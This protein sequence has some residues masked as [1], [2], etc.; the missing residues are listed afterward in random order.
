MATPTAHASKHAK[1]GSDPI[2]PESIGAMSDYKEDIPANSNMNNYTSTGLYLVTTANNKT[3]ANAAFEG[4][5]GTFY[6]VTATNN[7]QT[8]ILQEAFT[9]RNANIQKKWRIKS[10]DTIWTTWKEED[11]TYIFKYDNSL[12]NQSR[13]DVQAVWDSLEKA[14]G[15][16]ESPRT[17]K[18]PFC[19]FVRSGENAGEYHMVPMY[20]KTANYISFRTLS[21]DNILNIHFYNPYTDALWNGN[22]AGIIK[23]GWVAEFT[24]IDRNK[25]YTV[26][27]G[28]PAELEEGYLYYLIQ[29]VEE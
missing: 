17:D 20:K 5:V 10:S 6:R 25:F 27:Q 7:K 16:F 11:Q 2:T 8:R 3:L 13:E 12:K 22:S 18:I 15:T 19:H 23:R 28:L 26:E 29:E 14:I 4:N 1:D 9:I 21:A 24:P